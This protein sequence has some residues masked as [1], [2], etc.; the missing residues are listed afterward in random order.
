[1]SWRK[2]NRTRDWQGLS[3]TCHHGNWKLSHRSGRKQPSGPAGVDTWVGMLFLASNNVNWN[4]GLFHGQAIADQLLVLGSPK[5]LSADKWNTWG[6]QRQ[7]RWR[8]HKQGSETPFLTSLLETRLRMERSPT[9]QAA[10][11]PSFPPYPTPCVGNGSH[12][13]PP[14]YVEPGAQEWTTVPRTA[15]TDPALAPADFL[16]FD[17]ISQNILAWVGN[18]GKP[19]AES[20]GLP[21][22]LVKTQRQM[23]HQ[24]PLAFQLDTQTGGNSIYDSICLQEGFSGNVISNKHHS[25]GVKFLN[26]FQQSRHFSGSYF[27]IVTAFEYSGQRGGTGLALTKRQTRTFLHNFNTHLL[28]LV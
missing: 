12:L 21:R 10:P 13:L 17:F 26:P 18:V 3:F 20:Q 27:L 15:G 5:G 16:T 7:D 28:P 2:Q 1:M 14:P 9:I 25:K 11:F 23:G 4:Y 24:F 8:R 6:W 22:L 19:V